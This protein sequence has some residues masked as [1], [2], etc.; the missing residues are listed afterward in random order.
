MN[1]FKD[2]NEDAMLLFAY[3]ALLATLAIGLTWAF[4]MAIAFVYRNT[5][6]SEKI[7]SHSAWIFNTCQYSLILMLLSFLLWVPAILL[8]KEDG[9]SSLLMMVGI[10]IMILCFVFFI[11][12]SVKGFIYFQR[13]KIIGNIL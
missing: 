13:G 3:C 2:D 9:F 7:R 8:K 4:S 5:M 10:F 6:R 11:Y 1:N 12:R